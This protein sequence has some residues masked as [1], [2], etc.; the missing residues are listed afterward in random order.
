M[1]S[2]KIEIVRVVIRSAFSQA[3]FLTV[4][5]TINDPSEKLKAWKSPWTHSPILPLHVFD[6]DGERNVTP[7]KDLFDPVH[8]TSLDVHVDG[9]DGIQR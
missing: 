8:S 4:N 7:L 3:T 6:E 2:F 5:Q 9:Q 1:I